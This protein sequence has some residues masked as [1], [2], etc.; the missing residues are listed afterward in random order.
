MKIKNIIKSGFYWIWAF[1]YML[2]VFIRLP[3]F[4]V[5]FWLRGIVLTISNFVGAITFFCWLFSWFAHSYAP[6]DPMFGPMIY[7]CAIT[8]ICCFV[9]GWTFDFL[10]MLLSPQDMTRIYL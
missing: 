7:P 6:T 5:L 3:L 10:I 1:L 4:F 2:L 9:F 8:S